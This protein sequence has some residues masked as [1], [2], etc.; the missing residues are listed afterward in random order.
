MSSFL[1]TAWLPSK[2]K[3]FFGS[4]SPPLHY[5]WCVFSSNGVFLV[6]VLQLSILV[7]VPSSGGNHKAVASSAIKRR[8]AES[9]L[10]KAKPPATFVIPISHSDGK[11]GSILAARSSAYLKVAIC[12]KQGRIVSFGPQ[13]L[14][15]S[16][17]YSGH[18]LKFFSIPLACQSWDFFRTQCTIG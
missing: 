18:N 10:G 4:C 8:L 15:R 5:S 3:G 7:C 12:A 1:S 11:Q 13:K 9:K 16:D 6:G 17:Q 14:G 2:E